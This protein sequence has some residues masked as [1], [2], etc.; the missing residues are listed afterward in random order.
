[1]I[2]GLNLLYL[3][4]GVVGGTET[5]AAGLLHGLSRTESADHFVVFVNLES[6]D[7]PLPDD[8]RF[9]RV[10]CPVRAVSRSARYRY[11]QF[12]LPA[13]ARAHG[14]DVLHSLGYVA[15]LRLQCPSVVTVHDVHHLAHGRLRDW[16]R[17]LLLGRIVRRS[18]RGAAAVIA[19]SRFMR[20]AIAEAYDMPAR[21]IDV[22]PLAPNPALNGGAPLPDG[23]A[24]APVSGGPY[25]LAFGGVTP[26]KNLDGLLRAFALAR[27]RHGVRQNLVVV[28]HLPESLRIGDSAG[29]VATGYLDEARLASVLAKAEALVFPSLYEGFGLPVLE[30]MAAGVPVICS[31]VTAIP[32]VAGEAAVYFDPRDVEDMA[33]KLALVAHDRALREDLAAR[34][35]I[36]AA[37]FSWERAARETR[38]IYGRV[39]G[40]AAVAPESRPDFP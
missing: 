24:P 4:P 15:P 8:P 22:V 39:A 28:G 36:R 35:R 29:V 33:S 13:E 12:R 18:V 20:D 34:G 5:Y 32:E 27:Q 40:P 19:D 16:H 2:I 31:R 3:L 38:A 25:L 1:V 21:S 9:H 37:S 6:A 26:N 30:A 14:V 23:G 17:R 10:V 11:E 7:W